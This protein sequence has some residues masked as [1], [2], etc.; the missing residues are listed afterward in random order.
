MFK[1]TPNIKI[2]MTIEEPPLEKNG[3]GTPE[4]GAQCNVDNIFKNIWEEK[5]A[6]IPMIKNLA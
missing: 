1:I 6:I 2:V 4:T 5:V 3:K